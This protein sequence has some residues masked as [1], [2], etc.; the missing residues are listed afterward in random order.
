ML[1]WTKQNTMQSLELGRS[2][3]GE[4]LGAVITLVGISQHCTVVVYIVISF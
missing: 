1:A 2:V 3:A 4:S